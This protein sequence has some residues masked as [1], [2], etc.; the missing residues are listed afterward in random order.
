MNMKRAL[1]AAIPLAAAFT[2]TACKEK[3]IIAVD[4]SSTVGPITEAVAE[5]FQKGANAKVTVGISGT[6]GG[7]KKFCNGETDISDAS[8]PIK[9][10]EIEACAAKQIEYIELPIAYDGIAIMVNPQNTWVKELTVDQLKKIFTSESPAKTWKDVDPS[11]PAEEIKLYSP[12][13][14]NGTHDYFVEE[15]LGKKKQIRPD[16][17][18]STT[19]N[20]LATGIAGD[21]NSIGYFGLAYYESNKDKLKLVPVISPKTNKA[22]SPSMETVKGGEYAPLSRPLFIYV[23]TKAASK[24]EVAGFVDYY[25][26]NVSKL[27]QQVGYFNLPDSVYEKVKAR[28]TSKKTGTLPGGYEG[29]VLE[30]IL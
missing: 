22:V 27:A 12:S 26:A 2:L 21:K 16:A 25:L 15:V 30:Q 11:W 19:P 1:L 29:K 9:K 17:S 28:W 6:G 13:K 18:F 3:K 14:D 24:E 10:E 20:V 23:S 8:R 7:F 5:E 4:G